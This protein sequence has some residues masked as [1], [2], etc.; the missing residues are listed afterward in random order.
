MVLMALAT[1]GV[2]TGNF[3]PITE[4]PT[5]A[6]TSSD[7]PPF[8]LYDN[9]K[10]LGNQ[11]PPDGER[12]RGRG[13][14]LLSGRANYKRYSAAIGLGEQLVEYPDLAVEPE[15]AAKVFA[16]TIKEREDAFR[17]ALKENNLQQVRRLWAGGSLG[18][19]VFMKAFQTGASLLP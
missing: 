9:R 6:N 13:F 4:L 7:G 15:I 10:E 16:A 1:I 8:D 2:D 11:G 12:F 17:S 18:L 5:R 3:D 19:Q 14:V